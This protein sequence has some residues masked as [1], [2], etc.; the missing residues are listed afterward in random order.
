MTEDCKRKE[1]DRRADDRRAMSVAVEYDRRSNQRRS[2][3]DRRE[4]LSGQ[5]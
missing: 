4:V 3:V 2:G 1:N 5:V